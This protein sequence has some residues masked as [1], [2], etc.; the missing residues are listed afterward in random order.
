[1]S[2]LELL[3]SPESLQ[4]KRVLPR[5][6]YGSL[7]FRV[8]STQSLY[9]VK[10]ISLAGMQVALKLGEHPHKKGDL[11][12]GSLRWKGQDLEVKGEVR[13]ATEKRLGLA[14]PADPSYALKEL[15]SLKNLVQGMRPV[16]ELDLEL[17]WPGKLTYWLR[18]DGPLEVFVWQ[19]D[20]GE[21]AEFQFVL[22]DS[23]VEWKDGIGIRSGK[24]LSKRDLETPLFT[25]DEFLFAVD[26]VLDSEKLI[27]S[28]ELL[29]HIPEG[30]L[31]EEVFSFLALK[32]R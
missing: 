2:H 30:Y 8:E 24:I 23:F 3:K 10:D 16:H 6:P 18:G 31:P 9:E 12:T 29:S 27:K 5:F 1:M 21:F 22:M 26:E 32:L 25:E 20:D 17:E 15:L 28:Q 7:L 4:E 13:W 11:V 14:F 19:H